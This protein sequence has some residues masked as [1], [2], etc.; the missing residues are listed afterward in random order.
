[1]DGTH[2][3]ASCAASLQADDGHDLCP[4]CLGLDHLRE[5]LSENPCMNCSYMSRALRVARLAQ[6][7]SDGDPSPP[8]EA[9]PPRRAR[10]RGE[11]TTAPPKKKAKS[12][13]ALSSKVE[14]LSAELAEMK[15]LL[16]LRQSDTVSEEAGASVQDMP[17][18]NREDDVLSLAASASQFFDEYDG[19]A[20]HTS[21]VSEVGSFSP[22]HSS[23]SDAGDDSMQSVLR[24]AL[25]RLHVDVPQQA[26]V[27]PESAFFRRGRPPSTFTVPPSAEYLR[28]LHACWRDPS[29]LSRLSA[30]GRALA[31]MH[32]AAEAGL[33]HMPAVEPAIA[34]LI[35]S[36][37]EALR[38]TVQCPRPQCRV[39]DDLLTRTY[40]AGARAGRLGNSLAHLMFALSASLQGGS[41]SADSIVFSDAA[42]QAFALLTR[43]LGR[44]MSLL[45]RARR[46]VW[47]AQS[48]LTEACR[49][50]LRSVPVEP[51]VL[52]GPAALE[53]LERTI[54]AQETR[55][56]LSGLNRSM[57]PPAGSRGP[58]PPPRTRSSPR[59]RPTAECYRQH[60]AQRRVGNEF[61][62]PPPPSGQ[63]QPRDRPRR[64]PRAPKGHGA[65][66]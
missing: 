64:P 59:V 29:A 26:A 39:T 54:Q 61:R 44:M 62:T 35:V 18:L 42:L 52:F 34:S 40:N 43:E 56:Q 1:M 11:P 46:Q 60:V 53:A 23:L 38:P 6:L 14:R 36:P 17:V 13:S 27:T 45:C 21:H 15:S 33:E 48:P 5:G 16:Q 57:P 58:P 4:A 37:E 63:A 47:L 28:E 65:R 51:G 12:D 8:G 24:M 22:S 19:A 32:N 55:Q 25:E 31:A 49:K 9:A 10:R 2:C 50:T 66:R 30:D 41:A 7:T 3:C 20:S